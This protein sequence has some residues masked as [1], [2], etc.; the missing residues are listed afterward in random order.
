MKDDTT[1]ATLAATLTPAELFQRFLHGPARTGDSPFTPVFQ[2]DED[3]STARDWFLSHCS[4]LS[5]Y[6]LG[7]EGLA[8]VIITRLEESDDPSGDMD[9]VIGALSDALDAMKMLQ[10]AY[11]AMTSATPMTPRE[12]EPERHVM[13]YAIAQMQSLPHDRQDVGLMD[14]CCRQVRSSIDCLLLAGLLFVV[15]HDLER[16]I[17]L[18]P[19]ACGN[20]CDGTY[21]EDQIVLRDTVRTMVNDLKGRFAGPQSSLNTS[22]S[23]AARLAK[24]DDYQHARVA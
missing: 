17:N 18:W 2:D 20:D 7:C 12:V 1:P 22:A 14:R 15:E 21:T 6:P 16:E 4:L 5:H 11:D 23:D 19:D 3:L 10:R 8:E 13:L 9:L 24:V